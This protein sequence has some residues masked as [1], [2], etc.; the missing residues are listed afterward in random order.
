MLQFCFGAV[1]GVIS[2]TTS[3]PFDIVRRRMQTDKSYAKLGTLGTLRKVIFEEGLV[4]GLYKGLSLNWIK[5]PIAVGL[6]FTSFELISKL[7]LKSY[8]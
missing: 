6:S 8:I 5:G 2:Q 3:Y 4:Q 7:L 1:A